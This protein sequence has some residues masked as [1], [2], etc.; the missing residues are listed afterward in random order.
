MENSKQII[1]H[2]NSLNLTFCGSKFKFEECRVESNTH[3]SYSCVLLHGNKS[4][5]CKA[6]MVLSSNY[7]DKLIPEELRISI[8]EDIFFKGMIKTKNL[9]EDFEISFD[10]IK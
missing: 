5:S 7:D 4:I 6:R 1:E 8:I 9:V 3:V 10:K 2:L